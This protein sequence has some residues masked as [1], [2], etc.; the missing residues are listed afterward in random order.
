MKILKDTLFKFKRLCVR[1]ISELR[2]IHM[3][4]MVR[5]PPLSPQF[6]GYLWPI[7]QW[8]PKEPPESLGYREG[9]NLGNDLAKGIG[10]II[11]S[12]ALPTTSL[13]LSILHNEPLGQI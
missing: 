4:K 8:A 1:V 7:K 12:S 5:I 11:K 10:V 6:A 2:F 9:G 3:M 13:I